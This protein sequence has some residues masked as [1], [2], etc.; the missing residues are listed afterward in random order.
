MKHEEDYYKGINGVKI[1]YQVWN[2]DENPK[3]IVQIVHGL[4]EHSNRYLNVVN[5]LVP[6]G[7]IIYASDLRGHGKTES[8]KAYTDKFDYFIEDQKIFFDLIKEKEPSLPIF[9]LGHSMGSIIARIYATTYSEGLKGLILSGT[10]T[11]DGTGANALL[12]AMARLFSVLRPKGLIDPKLDPETISRDPEVVKAYK[13]DP[14]VFTKITIR[15]GA[16]LLKGFKK[17]NKT[18][19]N[20]KLPTLIQAGSADKLMLE[21][22]EVGKA[23]KFSD[24]TIKIY[25]GLYHEVYNELEEDRK[26]VL[27]DLGEWL[28]SH[29]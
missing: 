8:L 17:A 16:E 20:I 5:E 1:Y 28:D 14:L 15:L 13:E 19:S 22:E 10:G 25:D 21:A 2:P 12:K 7:Y 6:K 23:M 4:A 29:L 11:K 27:K 24:I 18:T 9:L 3:A 26:I